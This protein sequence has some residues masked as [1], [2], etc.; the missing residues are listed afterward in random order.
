MSPM[1]RVRESPARESRRRASRPS[2][3]PVLPCLLLIP[4][5][6]G[7][8]LPAPGEEAPGSQAPDPLRWFAPE[9][10]QEQET[11]ERLLF[12]GPSPERLRTYHDLL[13]S[14]PHVAGSAG[15]RRVIELLAEIMG[16]FGLEVERQELW[17]YLPRPVR[18]EVRLVAPVERQ[19]P[20]REAVLPEDPYSAHA[21][22]DP[23]WNAYSG[24]GSA[25]A[26]VVYA[27]YGTKEDF[28][29]LE[30]LGVEVAGK[31]AIARYGRNFRG[32]KAYFA[33]KAGAAGLLIY[34]DPEDSGY[35]RG[36][37][38]PVGGWAHPTSIQRGSVLTLPYPGDP[39]TPFEPATREAERRPPEKVAFHSIPVQPLGW[40]AA[41]EIL[42]RMEG[43]AVPED[44]QGALPF[45]YRLTGGEA[46]KVHMEVAQ[47]RQLTRTENVVG[48][49]RG[50]EHP[51]QTVVVGCHHDAWSFGAGDPNAGTIVVLELARLFARAA[52]V[53]L[54][55]DRTLVFA[56][57]AAEEFGIL[58]SVE[59]VE[60]RR[61]E[62]AEGGVAY[63]NLDMAA[64]GPNFNS[65]AAPTLQTL[66]AEAT[67]GVPK[68]GDAETT[69]HEDWT[70]RSGRR[71]GTE[72]PAMGSLG[73]GSDHVGFYTHVGI[74]SAG[75]S[76]WG[77][78]G[79]SYHTNYE[80][81]AWYRRVVGE[82]YAP[83]VMLT[84]IAGR[85]AARLA[86]ADLLP[87]DP[88]LYGPETRRH[89]E[90]VA[91][92]AEELGVEADLA[93]LEARALSFSEGA[94]GRL[95]AALAALAAGEL[96]GEALEAANR[97]LLQLERAWI[98]ERGLPGRP[99]YRSL[100]A[101][102]DADS[103]YAAWMLPALRHA[104]ED[105][106]SRPGSEGEP[107][108]VREAVER[109]LEIFDRLEERLEA[110]GPPHTDG[111]MESSEVER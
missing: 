80:D 23:G 48:V 36:R 75:M 97:A 64:M 55:P 84:R 14:E 68:A 72:L 66:I 4:L 81:L 63:L 105:A 9:H 45:N 37:M 100:Y 86:N 73:G 82:D 71:P 90:G 70:A 39:L 1:L 79:V 109:Y 103:G 12:E 57:W 107:R 89:L 87:M 40:D 20:V 93:A 42:S 50:A 53:G 59:W 65:S 60:A 102:P 24:N 10:R 104:V 61:R 69:V 16:T 111:R 94:S 83:A 30:E 2:L 32:Y 85:I 74:P 110:V 22:L 29:R 8:A 52:E 31:I 3:R 13:S 7:G 77:S 19:L 92:R 46:L 5:F 34:T 56:H 95:D 6:L 18:G 108:A 49:L 26:G 67:R 101:A 17:L 21:A 99:W 33:E 96:K 91:A 11:L 51:E 78:P 43:A 54:R 44:W 58:G 47:E 35:V 62:L 98:D 28:E 25:E 38:W 41:S 106:G 27:N 88:H 76:G 15:D